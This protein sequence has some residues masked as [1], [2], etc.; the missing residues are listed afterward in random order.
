V[1][2]TIDNSEAN[3]NHGTNEQ[4]NEAYLAQQQLFLAQMQQNQM[5]VQDD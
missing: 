1:S 3:N 4:N 5:P 2:K